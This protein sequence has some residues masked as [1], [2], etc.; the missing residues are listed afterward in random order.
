MLN[1]KYAVFISTFF[2]FLLEGLFHYNIGKNSLRNFQFP[3]KYD[4]FKI[5]FILIIFSIINVF[6]SK[7]LYEYDKKE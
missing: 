7:L 1:F 6:V 2:V 4:L 5:I 3:N